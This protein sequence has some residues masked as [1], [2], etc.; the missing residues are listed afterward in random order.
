[1]EQNS[2]ATERLVDELEARVGSGRYL[3]CSRPQILCGTLFELYFPAAHTV[4]WMLTIKLFNQEPGMVI[5]MEDT[6]SRPRTIVNRR[7][8]SLTLYRVPLIQTGYVTSRTLSA[9]TT[10]LVASLM[11]LTPMPSCAADY[12]L[13]SRGELKHDSKDDSPQCSPEHSPLLTG[14]AIT[15][16][17]RAAKNKGFIQPGEAGHQRDIDLT[18]NTA[19]LLEDLIK[20]ERSTCKK[21]K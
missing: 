11:M 13:G 9:L 14:C 16:I 7:G 17:D 18:D 20:A 10:V 6:I 3:N 8:L 4:V 19:G 12:M 5:F 1:M 15:G 21:I 2:N